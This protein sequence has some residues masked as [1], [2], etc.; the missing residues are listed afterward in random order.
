M[1]NKY[2]IFDCGFNKILELAEMV[3]EDIVRNYKKY[4]SIIP[5]NIKKA[6]SECN[7]FATSS[8]TYSVDY[9]KFD[10]AISFEYANKKPY[11]RTEIYINKLLGDDLSPKKLFSLSVRNTK[12]KQPDLQLFYEIKDGKLNFTGVSEKDSRNIELEWEMFLQYENFEPYIIFKKYFRGVEIVSKEFNMTFDELTGYFDEDVLD[13]E[14]E[15]SI[16]F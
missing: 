2:K 16:E 13:E 7:D 9:M 1:E 3:D 12:L 15:T 10:N 8:S 5:A 6:V 4:I 11:L 14:S